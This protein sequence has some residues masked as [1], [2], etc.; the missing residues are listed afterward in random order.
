[1]NGLIKPD[2]KNTRFCRV[3]FLL[4]ILLLS[5]CAS[6]PQTKQLLNEVGYE[7]TDSVEI[8]DVPFFPQE[9]YQCGPAALATVLAFADVDVTPAQ[10]VDKVYVPERQGSLQVEMI[11]AAR[12]HNRIPYRIKPELSNILAEL[13][14]QRPV[15]VLQN[16]G[17]SWIPQ[18][19]YAVV[20]GYDLD[21]HNF[22]LRSGEL[23]RR[24]T[25]MSVFEHTWR[26]SQYW[27]LVLLR[28]GELPA[29]ADEQQYF[30]AVADF[31]RTAQSASTELALQAGLERWPKSRNLNMALAN[32]YHAIGSLRQAADS[33]RNVV[34]LYPDFA[35]AHNNLAMTLNEIGDIEAA[36]RHAFKAVEIGGEF[37]AEYRDT[38]ESIQRIDLQ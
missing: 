15:L 28:P 20:V 11:A 3:F 12:T 19:H 32:H 5:G 29:I 23:Q 4:S 16:L 24:E 35:P 21:A 10:L 9:K 13:Q 36:L 18:W 22:V 31:T 8:A 30:L 1:M 25:R 2:T 7:Y 34:N 38:L 33:Y 37:E 17:I 26:R 6:A 27:G 14:Q